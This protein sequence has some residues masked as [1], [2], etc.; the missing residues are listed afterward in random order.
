MRLDFHIE[1]PSSFDDKG[2]GHDTVID[3]AQIAVN[4]SV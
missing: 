2:P 1:R 3:N 4:Q